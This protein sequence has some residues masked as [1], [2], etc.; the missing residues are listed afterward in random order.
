MIGKTKE[1]FNNWRKEE[2]TSDG[3][4]GKDINLEEMTK[5]YGDEDN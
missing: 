4:S 1:M 5:D 2:E 3:Q